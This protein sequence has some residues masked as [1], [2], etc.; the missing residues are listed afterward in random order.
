MLW[1]SQC[2]WTWCLI[3]HYMMNVI[4][5]EL[6][7]EAES[8]HQ[9]EATEV[10][11]K[12]VARPQGRW[13][14]ECGLKIIITQ[15]HYCSHLLND[16]Q[17]CWTP[18]LRQMSYAVEIWSLSSRWISLHAW[19]SKKK[20]VNMRILHPTQHDWCRLQLLFLIVSVPSQCTFLWLIRWTDQLKYPVKIMNLAMWHRYK[21]RECGKV[22]NHYSE[23]DLQS[24][25]VNIPSF[26]SH[27]RGRWV[28]LTLGH[29]EKWLLESSSLSSLGS[30][31]VNNV[32][33]T[34]SLSHCLA[35]SFL[36]SKSCVGL[37]VVTG[38]PRGSDWFTQWLFYTTGLQEWWEWSSSCNWS[39]SRGP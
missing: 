18:V 39:V 25:L 28:E 30:L 38:K 8:E 29:T 34:L 21:R 20:G 19:S 7:S 32:M 12:K 26:L 37:W 3:I 6:N 2:C 22:V 17:H 16:H 31:H 27:L 36:N 33:L 24:I 4:S 35:V 14:H 13:V 1:N 23:T 5:A 15:L 9:E 10:E 11:A